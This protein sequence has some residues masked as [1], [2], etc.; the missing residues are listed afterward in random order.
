MR[1]SVVC[2]LRRT[3]L[4]PPIY[5]TAVGNDAHIRPYGLNKN[6]LIHPGAVDTSYKLI[7]I[8]YK[9]TET[10]AYTGSGA[11]FGAVRVERGKPSPYNGA[12]DN[13]R[14]SRRETPCGSL[15]CAREI[16]DFPYRD[17]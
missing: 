1:L 15:L 3:R 6:C 11:R 4:V 14:S 16:T 12:V 2:G 17:G 13:Y 9:L 8:N 5:D 10:R 7:T